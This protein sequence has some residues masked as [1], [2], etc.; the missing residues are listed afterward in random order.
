M[1]F[2]KMYVQ[3]HETALLPPIESRHEPQGH[4]SRNWPGWSRTCTPRS[5][6]SVEK[7]VSVQSVRQGAKREGRHSGQIGGDPGVHIS[8]EGCLLWWVAS[9]ASVATLKQLECAQ[10]QVK[11]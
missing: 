10:L 6:K 1:Q 4:F 11:H 7:L 5:W 3:Q 8:D 9:S 2:M